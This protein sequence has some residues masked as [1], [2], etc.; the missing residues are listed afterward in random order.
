M[1]NLFK[2]HM[3]SCTA[4]MQWRLLLPDLSLH[5]FLPMAWSHSLFRSAYTGFAPTTYSNLL[6]RNNDH[7]A[8]SSG[9]IPNS[10]IVGSAKAAVSY[11]NSANSIS[12]W[13][14]PIGDGLWES[15]TLSFPTMSS[16][17]SGSF[18][19]GGGGNA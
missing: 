9:I 8:K 6:R 4:S 18:S 19:A 16:F 11:W 7:I 13:R 5:V 12:F 10:T 14:Q 2:Y 17:A 1:L 3:G 15:S